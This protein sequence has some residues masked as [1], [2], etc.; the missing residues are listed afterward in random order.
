MDKWQLVVVPFLLA[1]I[2]SLV[3]TPITIW[4]FQR[5]GLVVDPKKQSHPAHVHSAPVPKGGGIPIALAVLITAGVLLSWDKHLIAIALGLGICLVVGLADDIRSINPYWRLLANLLAAVVVVGSGIGIAYVTNPFGGTIDLSQIR[6]GFDFL[7]EHREIWLLA[8]LFALLW[9]PFLINS[10]N[11]SSG[12]D[13]Q[14]SGVV[15]IAALV[16]GLLSLSFSADI[17]QWPVAVLAF[18]LSGAFV[19]L[20]FF[21]FY[22]QKIMPGYSA[23]STAGFLLA[24]LAILATAKVG[25]ALVVLGLPLIDAV[26]SIIRRVLSGKSPVWGDKGHFH[27][28]LLDLGW[29]KRRIALFYWFLTAILGT[30]ALL[31][32]AEM[33]LFAI[34]GLS[35]I[36]AGFLL[37]VYFGPF[38]KQSD[39]ANG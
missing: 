10:I 26:Y 30:I 25:T 22:P 31:T 7:G 15:A 35:V 32:N 3:I 16:I 18:S 11:W 34:L 1:L 38:L 21:H 28:K 29:G 2:V 33:K 5:L 23:T 17:T 6:L 19:G 39:R 13:G 9:I 4:L 20:A 36:I 24:V 12:L 14:V 8:D 37:W 27:H